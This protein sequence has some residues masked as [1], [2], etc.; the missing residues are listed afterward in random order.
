VS[1]S[2]GRL[3]VRTPWLLG[4]SPETQRIDGSNPPRFSKQSKKERKEGKEKKERKEKKEKKRVRA[5]LV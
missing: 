4:T 2:G 1:R 5:A 3:V